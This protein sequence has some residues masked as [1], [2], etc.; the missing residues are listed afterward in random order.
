MVNKT[1][2]E[3]TSHVRQACTNKV[4]DEAYNAIFINFTYAYNMT[5]KFLVLLLLDNILVALQ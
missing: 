4:N 2:D 3:V 5:I 1:Q